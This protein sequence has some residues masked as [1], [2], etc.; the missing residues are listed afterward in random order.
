M[1]VMLAMLAMLAMLVA[2]C[3]AKQHSASAPPAPATRDGGLDD[4]LGG[5][6]GKLLR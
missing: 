6:A 1:L 3:M 5:M 2:G 4:L